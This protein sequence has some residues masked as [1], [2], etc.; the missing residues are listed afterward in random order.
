MFAVGVVLATNIVRMAFYLVLSL[1]ASSGLFF[2]AGAD[3]VVP[4][5]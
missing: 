2:L 3:F 1:S 4:C 5:N